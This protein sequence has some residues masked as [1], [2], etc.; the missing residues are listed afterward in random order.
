MPTCPP[1]LSLLALEWVSLSLPLSLSIPWAS[2]LCCFSHHCLSYHPFNI[3]TDQWFFEMERKKTPKNLC[4]KQKPG[5][6]GVD[7]L[8]LCTSLVS[9]S[10]AAVWYGRTQSHLSQQLLL[11]PLLCTIH[12]PE[13]NSASSLKEYGLGRRRKRVCSDSLTVAGRLQGL[14]WSV[15]AWNFS[16]GT[17]ASLLPEVPNS[18]S[19]HSPL[20]PLS[21][22]PY[23]LCDWFLGLKEIPWLKECPRRKRYGCHFGSVFSVYQQGNWGSWML[24]FYVLYVNQYVAWIESLVSSWMGWVYRHL[25]SAEASSAWNGHVLL[26][27]TWNWGEGLRCPGAREQGWLLAWWATKAVWEII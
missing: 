2:K 22:Q 12:Q 25:F 24:P 23:S 26:G 15:L 21:G 13:N 7:E 4:S 27:F 17:L 11:L 19:N 5:T 6:S 1:P 10:L 3:E 16:L 18:R 9:A 8:V 20:S 14:L